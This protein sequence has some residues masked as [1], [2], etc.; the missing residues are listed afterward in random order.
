DVREKI[1][2]LRPLLRD[3]VEE[4]RVLRFDPASRPVY[5]LAL[6]S[7][8]GSRDAVELST[9]ADQVLRKRLENV[10]GVG[11]VSLVGQVRREI[12]VYLEPEALQ[13][14]AVSVADVAAAVRTENR[15]LPAGAL[16]GPDTERI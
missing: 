14:H 15:E 2:A 8:D 4:P 5:I 3:E 16:V 10:R 1:A 9:F 7:P 12:N 13:A 11:S 6:T